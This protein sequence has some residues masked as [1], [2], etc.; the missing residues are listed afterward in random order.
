MDTRLKKIFDKICA[1]GPLAP[2][3]G[4]NE[5]EKIMSSLG[6]SDFLATVEA[7]TALFY[8]DTYDN[9]E[10]APLVKRT[11]EVLCEQKERAIRPLINKL[12]S[13][14]IKF[15]MNI[16]DTLGKMGA[17]SLR[18]LM[19]TYENTDDANTRIFALYAIGKIKDPV[20]RN[21][22]QLIIKAT[23][24]SNREI[25]DTAV[26]TAGKMAEVTPA[27]K[28][29]DYI[30]DQLCD[31]VINSA[32]DRSTAVRAKALRS[33]GKM[34]KNGYLNADQKSKVVKIS[35]NLLGNAEAEA[36]DAF[37]VRKEAQ[38]ALQQIG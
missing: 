13:T 5:A 17:A 20:V 8:M 34:A 29:P 1:T 10:F 7:L 22:V 14:D 23:G 19:E 35:H 28:L 36:D 32:K 31:E 33:L 11:S 25:R 27:S 24:D 15:V 21:A 37:I 6:E 18:T 16:A 26:R 38:F 12:N 4:V 3:E 2:M 9:P 30:R